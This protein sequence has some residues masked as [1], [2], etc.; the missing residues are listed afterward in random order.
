MN[1]TFLRDIMS[2]VDS[3]GTI[4]SVTAFD[5]DIYIDGTTYEVYGEK[6]FRLT[7][8]FTDKENNND[9]I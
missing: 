3:F 1:A 2:A 7:L 8:N 5:N 6:P 4:T 9:T